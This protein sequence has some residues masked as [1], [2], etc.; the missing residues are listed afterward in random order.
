MNMMSSTTSTPATTAVTPTDGKL[1][2]GEVKPISPEAMVEQLRLLRQ[3]IP[4]YSQL[5]NAS[6]SAL[7][8]AASLDPH[9]VQ[10]SINTIGA[11]SVMAGSV[12]RAPEALRQDA[13][14]A[15]RWTAV[16]D[17][18]KAM[19]KGVA[20]A[21]LTRRHRIGLIAL[22]TYSIS[23]QLVRQPE[24]ADLLP[25]VE[26]MKRLNRLGKRKPAPPEEVKKPTST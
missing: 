24:H 16:E 10:A 14:E 20:A 7:R 15:S 26:E 4:E 23:R 18:L 17:E 8:R 9:F 3:Q 2:E 13:D 19:L 12:G 1:A 6:A 22:Q 25:H 11:S 5:T 21:N